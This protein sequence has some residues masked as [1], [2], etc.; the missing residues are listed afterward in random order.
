MAE[1]KSASRSGSKLNLNE[2]TMPLLDEEA[3]E[4]A[5]TPEKDAIELKEKASTTSEAEKDDS[6]PE[7]VVRPIF[8]LSICTWRRGSGCKKPKKSWT[9]IDWISFWKVV[10]HTFGESAATRASTRRTNS[11]KTKEPASF[12]VFVSGRP[13]WPSVGWLSRQ[14]FETDSA[15]GMSS[16]PNPVLHCVRFPP[17]ASSVLFV[18]AFA[19]RFVIDVTCQHGRVVSREGPRVLLRAMAESNARK[20]L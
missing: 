9:F 12:F 18:F 2:S 20:C 13:I 10:W 3:H 1:T 15:N 17:L 8:V 4:K 7:K 19:R 6:N 11:T 16:R 5:E 14:E